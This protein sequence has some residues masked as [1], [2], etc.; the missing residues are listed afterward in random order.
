MQVL[1]IVG[2]LIQIRVKRNNVLGKASIN[3]IN[4]LLV[5]KT[6]SSKYKYFYEPRANI[7]DVFKQKWTDFD[8]QIIYTTNSDAMNERID[9]PIDKPKDTFRIITLGDSFTFGLNVSTVD[10][11]SEVLELELNK[12]P[13][14]DKY[15][16]YE[17]LNLGVYGY[18][19]DYAVE[20]YRLRG[21]KY[22][23]DLVVWLMKEDDFV[24]TEDLISKTRPSADGIYSVDDFL[25]AWDETVSAIGMDDLIET[26]IDSLKSI[27][28]YFKK[29]IIVATTTSHY[30]M[31]WIIKEFAEIEPNNYF[32]KLKLDEKLA[33]SDF[34]PN[35]QGHRYI[36]DKVYDSLVKNNLVPCE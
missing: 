15:K 10:N 28:N 32:L 14:C 13:I 18:D 9:Y 1:V 29:G 7:R 5:Y 25:E 26:R 19:I 20:R 33:F 27:R 17:V 31:S 8:K 16:N 36:A 12:K 35:E 24:F 21:A 3:P 22:N 11:W 34:H 23:P 6:P 2:I 30:K 4:R